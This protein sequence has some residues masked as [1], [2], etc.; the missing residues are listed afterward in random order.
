MHRARVM[1][2]VR[3][4]VMIRVQ[5]S[6]V[7]IFHNLFSGQWLKW[8][9]LTRNYSHTQISIIKDAVHLTCRIRGSA[10]WNASKNAGDVHLILAWGPGIYDRNRLDTLDDFSSIDASAAIRV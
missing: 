1:V 2:M 9:L 3:V 7:S 6:H 5:L 10:S 4:R 8:C